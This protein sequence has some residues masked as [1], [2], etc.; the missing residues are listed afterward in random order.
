MPI[1]LR[2]ISER[3]RRLTHALM[4]AQEQGWNAE[5]THPSACGNWVQLT[6]SGYRWKAWLRLEDWL[7]HA[8]PSLAE[9][10]ISAGAEQEVAR[11]LATC[12]KPLLFQAPQLTYE[13]LWIGEVVTA[14]HLPAG[15]LLRV[16]S[17][18][19]PVWFEDITISEPA[20]TFCVTDDIRWS[21]SLV[22][23]RSRITLELLKKA[24]I[25][26]V[27]LIKESVSE[28][29]CHT[30]LLGYFS[31]SGEECILDNIQLQNIQETDHADLI[32][33]SQLPVN[34]EFVLYHQSTTLA[35]LQSMYQGKVLSLPANVEC[36]IGIR[37]NGAI[38]G[39][40]ELVQLD[41]SIGVEIKK[42]ISDAVNGE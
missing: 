5:L 27:L 31:R 41:N 29:Y 4:F 2:R 21:L 24:E 42:W 37:V 9:L 20:G 18:N 23:G 8:A 36:H 15:M 1:S 26:D 39:Y 19:G 34:L 16:M 10:A 33:F 32:D 30:K 3:E 28:V 12:Q 25:G 40:G 7:Q 14:K 13:R 6:E 22:M 11:W 38:I 17:D 35:E